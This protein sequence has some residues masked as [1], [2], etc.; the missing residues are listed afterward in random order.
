MT[1]KHGYCTRITATI[2]YGI[3]ST[4]LDGQTFD[5]LWAR[6][7]AH[8]TLVRLLKYVIFRKVV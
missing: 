6:V 7:C 5:G 8:E 2:H 3:S 1:R 4:R